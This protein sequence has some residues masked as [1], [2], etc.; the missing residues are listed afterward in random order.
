MLRLFGGKNVVV[1]TFFDISDMNYNNEKCTKLILFPL[2]LPSTT[3]QH[4]LFS[5]TL[6]IICIYVKSGVFL[7]P[8]NRLWKKN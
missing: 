8:K 7:L 1:F 2:E 4:F 5:L 3:V 6:S